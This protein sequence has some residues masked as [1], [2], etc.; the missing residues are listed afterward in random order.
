MF[1]FE[2]TLVKFTMINLQSSCFWSRSYF[3]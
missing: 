2:V 1:N 3:G